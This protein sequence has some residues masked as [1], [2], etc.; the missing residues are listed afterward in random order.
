VSPLLS[1]D[2]QG[3]DKNAL[4]AALSDFLF[5]AD[6]KGKI[7]EPDLA[8]TQRGGLN[9]ADL[10]PD[11]RVMD[12][13]TILDANWQ[14]YPVAG[15]T[16]VQRLGDVGSAML[17]LSGGMIAKGAEGALGAGPIKAYH[18]SPHDFDRFSLDK[19]GTG[20]GA[21]AYGHGLYFAEN[22]GV[23]KSYRDTL[24]AQQN[25]ILR[26]KGGVDPAYVSAAKDFLAHGYSP[27]DT[28][29]GLSKAYKSADADMLKA[30]LHTATTDGKGRMYEVAIHAD[31]ER[32]LDWDKPLSGAGRDFAGPPSSMFPENMTGAELYRFVSR[33]QEPQAAASLR[34]AGIPGIKYLD[35]GSRGAGTGTRNYV[36]FD[37]AIIEIIKKYGIAGLALLPS[38][39]GMTATEGV[40]DTPP[41]PRKPRDFP[42]DRAHPPMLGIRG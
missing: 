28:L 40:P 1:A 38:A 4:L 37:P 31:P 39:M 7:A 23:A 15:R 9:M 5:G 19:I 22:E 32:F 16:P 35:G 26:M 25:A 29:V 21:Q 3:G 20:E 10:P 42:S 11:A 2:A 24:A 14:P 33:G 12:D 17:P 30:A 41:P 34:E 36:A 6:T 8:Q 13:G 18:G 27:E